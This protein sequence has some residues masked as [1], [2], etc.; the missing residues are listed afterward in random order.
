[1]R[2][3]LGASMGKPVFKLRFSPSR[4]QHWASRYSYPGEDFIVQTLAPAARARGYLARREFLHLCHWKSPRSQP[5][6]AMNSAARVREATTIALGTADEPAKMYIL[7][8]L[9]GV[10]WPTASVIVH[11]CDKRPYPIL[12]YRALWSL[13]Y[14]RPP[15]YSFDFW[16]AY[17][18][19]CRNLAR[20]TRNDMRTLD[21]AL[22]QY[23]KER[24]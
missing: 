13:G 16:W 22:W 3:P 8:T 7:R 2:N 4:I 6:C 20:S 24:Q 1:M 15:T 11:F 21:Q 19:F 12:D 9:A 10:E 18:S 5:R 14:V 17:T 23:S